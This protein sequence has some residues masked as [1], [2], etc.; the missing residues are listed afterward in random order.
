VLPPSNA[1]LQKS[2]KRSPFLAH[3]AK[4]KVFYGTAPAD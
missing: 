3:F 1:V 2:K 4:L